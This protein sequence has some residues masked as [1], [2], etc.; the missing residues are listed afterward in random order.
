FQD[1]RLLQSWSL[2]LLVALVLVLA[3]GLYYLLRYGL[4]AAA[5]EEQLARWQER[6]EQRQR[7]RQQRRA[8]DRWLRKL[9]WR[10]TVLS[11]PSASYQSCYLVLSAGKLAP[12]AAISQL[13][14]VT[15]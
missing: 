14:P 3:W 13:W 1:R 12:Y 5:S 10:K 9:L 11:G 6:R 8:L 7:Q 4:P 2:R 15:S